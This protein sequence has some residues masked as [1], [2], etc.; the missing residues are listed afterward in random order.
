[1]I[2]NPPSFESMESLQLPIC[3][4]LLDLVKIDDRWAQVIFS[5]FVVR[6]LD[7]Q[8]VELIDWRCLKLVKNWAE[9]PVSLLKQSISL[10]DEEIRHVHWGSEQEEFPRLREQVSVFGE[11]ERK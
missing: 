4:N 3:P 2:D 5:G 6:Y 11:F 1:M 7:D 9:Y 10:T 8:S